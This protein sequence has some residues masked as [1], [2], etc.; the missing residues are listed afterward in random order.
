MTTTPLHA[1]LV[2]EGGGV[3][4]IGLAGALATLEERG[5]RAAEHRRDVGR[6]DHRRAARGGLLRLGA[7]RDHH[8]ARLPPVPGPRLGG[9]GAADRALAEHAAR[10]RL[11]RGRP[12]PR[13]DPRA[14]RGEGRAHVR[15]PRPGGVR[16]RPA[17]PL[18][19]AGDRLRRDHARAARA[20]ARRDEARD[21]ARHAGRRARGADE[22]EH[23]DLLRARPLPEPED[24]PAA[25]DRRRRHA[26]EL[27]RLAVRLPR[28]R[29]AG[30]ADLRS[31]PRRAEA[32]DRRSARA[33]RSRG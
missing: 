13:L 30:V 16:R 26:L 29:G 19:A 12:L 15:R 32:A 4:G 11:L 5:I 27:P 31:A 7:A 18:A 8:G 24:R 1:D 22:H 14:P 6:R 10:P 25:R 20:P 2:F 28:R 21:R 33:C 9:Q 23:P 3:K 17:L